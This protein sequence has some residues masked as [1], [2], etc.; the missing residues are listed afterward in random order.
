MIQTYL[1]YVIIFLISILFTF[2]Y[3]KSKSID[4]G[5]L[6]I[7]VSGISIFTPKIIYYPLI[8]SGPVFLATVRWGIGIDFWGYLDIFHTLQGINVFEGLESRREPLYTLLNY[9]ADI[10]FN[11]E[12]WGI[13]FL[14]SLITILFIILTLDYYDE[15]V[16]L[17]M[18]LFIYF[19][20]YYIESFNL[21]RQMIALSIVLYSY[22]YIIERKL[23]EYLCAIIIAV[24]FHQSAF[25]CIFFYFLSFEKS[26]I[27]N[28]KKIPYYMIL[29]VLIFFGN[30]LL[31]LLKY[32]P[33]LDFY[34]ENYSMTNNEMG[35][36][37]LVETLPVLVPALFFKKTLINANPNYDLFINLAL[38]T[39]PLRIAA[40]YLNWA[41]RMVYYTAAIQII[42]IPIYLRL[43]KNSFNRRLAYGFFIIFY[44][45]LFIYYYV[46]INRGPA[47]PYYNIFTFTDSWW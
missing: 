29:I 23:M 17:P 20:L 38:L 2:L 5:A 18:G 30:S 36:G 46:V 28:F 31:P 25:L 37:F 13:F 12:D 47:Y 1:V 8:L 33:I 4:K 11:G 22:R 35:F 3:Q 43:I 7:K 39:I 19:M 16:S 14:A 41:E 44:V 21:V 26:K 10:L 6:R 34:V 40:Y 9:C 15:K 45:G 32:V 27:K 24:L 42:M